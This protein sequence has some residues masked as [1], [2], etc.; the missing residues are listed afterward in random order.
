MRR[1]GTKVVALVVLA[2][3]LLM[4]G[5]ALPLTSAQAADRVDVLTGF[6]RQPG[7]SQQALV[8][9]AGGSIKHTYR[10]VT[11]IAATLPQ[12][13]I[14]GLRRNPNVIAVE[15]DGEVRAIAQSLPWGIDRIDADVVHT[16][17]NK[18][19]GVKVAVID[20]GIDAT[21]LDL[22]VLGGYDFVNDDTDPA[23]D[24]GHGTHVAGTVAAKD[25]GIGVIGVAPDAELYALKVLGPSG[26]GSFSDVIAAVQWAVDNGIQVTNNSYGSS[27][28]PGGIVKSA[29]DN[30]AAAGLVQIAAGGN[31][32]SCLGKGNS[33]EWPARYDSV[34]AVAATN[35]S[36]QSPCFSSVGGALELAAPGVAINSTVPT[37][38]C[39]LCDPNG[40]MLLDGTSMA[41]P[42]VAGTAALVIAAGIADTNGNGLINDQVREQLNSTAEDIGLP[43]NWAGNGLVDAEA[44]AYIGEVGDPPP[45]PPPPPPPGG[46][47]VTSV[48]PD[49]ASLG[50]AKIVIIS[51]TGFVAGATVAL[52]NG[53]GP[54]P[55][56]SNVVVNSDTSIT[57]TISVPA[58]GGPKKPRVWDVVVSNTGGG[59]GTC[60]GCFTVN[61]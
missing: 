55:S 37:G 40:Y 49:Y 9:G 56:V 25:S 60:D 59:S 44:A 32:G 31:S 11:A 50:E 26:S 18:G 12:A 53:K 8:R 48:F 1:N 61:P 27:A 29:F 51:G 42:H 24:N 36:D 23:D 21:H 20:S 13:A 10:L 41:A 35:A 6:D 33:V 22:S 28:N 38:A 3:A 5:P 57:A 2:V 47:R 30:A 15:P 45:P 58:S 16:G 19:L 52:A 54:N 7:R 46:V 4:A 17:G 14:D 39:E 43:S 34:I